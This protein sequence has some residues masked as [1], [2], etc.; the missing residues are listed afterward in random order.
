METENYLF[1]SHF[2]AL[3]RESS[4][5]PGISR[6]HADSLRMIVTAAIGEDVS[7]K[8]AIKY[9]DSYPDIMSQ[10]TM[11]PYM[12][13]AMLEL[14]EQE[15]WPT[16]TTFTLNPVLSYAMLIHWRCLC[17]LLFELS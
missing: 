6:E 2:P 1:Q 8:D 10:T 17:L 4:A 11:H 15:G 9:V 12:D 13:P 3:F 7:N 16:P 5:W 14:C